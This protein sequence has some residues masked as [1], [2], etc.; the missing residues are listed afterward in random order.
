ML[1]YYTL[2]LFVAFGSKLLLALAMIY[3]L[4]PSERSCNSCNEDTLLIRPGRSGKI[5]SRLTFGRVQRRWCPRCGWDGL[6]RRVR[7]PLERQRR[8]ERLKSP[9]TTDT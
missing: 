9:F 7:P 6:A 4:L 1:F 5:F 8:S 3:M 2:F